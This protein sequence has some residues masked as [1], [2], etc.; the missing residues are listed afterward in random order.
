[1]RRPEHG[2]VQVIDALGG[3]TNPEKESII[4]KLETEIDSRAGDIAKGKTL[5]TA[6]CA[7]CHPFH[8]E[9]NDVGPVLD[10]IGVHGT[11]ELLVH[12]SIRA[13][14]WITSIAPGT[15]R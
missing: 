9:G 4:A 1:M 6:A 12:I 8:G 11:H 15:S 7:V 3:G 10:G 14:W 2:R 5:F 13:A